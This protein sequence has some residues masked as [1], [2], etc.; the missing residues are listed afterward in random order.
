MSVCLARENVYPFTNNAAVMDIWC[1]SS[2][3]LFNAISHK[4]NLN[5]NQF[6]IDWNTLWGSPLKNCCIFSAEVMLLQTGLIN[7]SGSLKQVGS[8]GLK[9]WAS[10]VQSPYFQAPNPAGRHDL[11]SQLHTQI[12]VPLSSNDSGAI[13]PQNHYS[14]STN[15][16]DYV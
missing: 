11:L 8:P 15:G 5:L 10:L 7:L 13:D 4:K 3:P 16:C 12:Y 1:I 6:S 14:T 9:N 2:T